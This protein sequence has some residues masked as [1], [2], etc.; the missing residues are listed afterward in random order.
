[1]GAPKRNRSTYD[2][3]KE[4][5]NLDRIKSDNA[6]KDE[7]GLKN[8]R[9]LWKAQTE[10]SRIRGNARELLAGSSQESMKTQL[11][12]RLERLGIARPGASLDDLLDLKP[13]SIL[14]RR[15]QTIVFKRGLARTIKQAR[16]LTTHGFIAIDGKKVNRPG[17][18]IEVKSEARIGY[19]KPIDIAAKKPTEQQAAAEEPA[20]VE[21]APAPAVEEKKS[22]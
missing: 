13:N 5:W 9:E 8:M 3:P 18:L 2:K 7:Y 6:L 11:I 12:A 14:E 4:R 1:M 15:L 16:Q 20:P 21:A 17:I 10:I 22:E 19:Y